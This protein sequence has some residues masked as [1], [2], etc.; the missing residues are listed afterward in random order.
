MKY[1]NLTRKEKEDWICE[2]IETSGSTGRI[3]IKDN[4][5]KKFRDLTENYTDSNAMVRGAMIFYF[6]NYI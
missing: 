4:L 1:E 6:N 5:V 2:R 3:I